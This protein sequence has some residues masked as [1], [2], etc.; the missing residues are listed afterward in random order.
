M[1]F[2]RNPLKSSFN[3][4]FF[5]PKFKTIVPIHCKVIPECCSP[6]RSERQIITNSTILITIRCD[7]DGLRRRTPDRTSQC[8]LTDL[9]RRTEIPF[10]QCRRQRERISIIVK[11]VCGIVRWQQRDI[12]IYCKQITDGVAILCTIQAMQSRPSRIRRGQRCAVK[13]CFKPCDNHLCLCVI[14]SWPANGR[15]GART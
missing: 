1:R 10:C 9:R 3:T 2:S 15:H 5:W 7:K 6:T 14:G 11:T 4:T 13:F 12:D 8:Y